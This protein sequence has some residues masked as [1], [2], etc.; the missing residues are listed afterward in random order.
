MATEAGWYP[1]AN[2]ERT[3]RY[4]DGS[5][6]TAQRSWDGAR[7]VSAVV[8]AQPASAAPEP[9]KAELPAS[10]PMPAQADIQAMASGVARSMT[11]QINTSIDA[12]RAGV[13]PSTTFSLLTGGA[14]AAVLG[15]FVPWGQVSDSGIT[16]TLGPAGGNKLFFAALAIFVAFLGL[17]TF[18][19][20]PSVRSRIG[21]TV[22]TAVMVFFTLIAY[23]AMVSN[24]Q[25]LTVTPG[26][27]LLLY[28]AGTA[29]IVVG[30][31][32]VWTSRRKDGAGT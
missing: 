4:W 30:V 2:D 24:N 14:L 20:K 31:V 1:D 25:G 9:E 5:A 7:W 26:L 21:M 23:P 32:R 11:G 28:G 22:I 29:A 12:F 13:R 19:G 18:A 27:G 17:S 15:S 3:T 8:S 10:A 6:W 16:E